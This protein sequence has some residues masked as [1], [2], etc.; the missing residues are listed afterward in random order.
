[1]KIQT[2]VEG[3]GDVIAVPVLLRRLRDEAGAYGL[4]VG[5]PIRSRHSDLVQETS[6]RKVVQLARRQPQCGAILVLLDSDDACPKEKAPEIEAW[7]RAE[8]GDVPVAVVMAKSEFEAWFL[9]A[10]ESL[11]GMRG[12]VENAEPP[13]KPEEIR[14]AKERLEELMLRGRSY[15][16][17]ADQAALAAQFDMSQAYR[18]CRSF[19][20]LA[21]VFGRLVESLG[22]EHNAWPP[23]SWQAGNP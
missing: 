5:R 18:E 15:S 22:V 12:I 23:D 16:E 21:S 6:L 10:V 2:I 7:A 3:Y 8:T 11:R 20:R 9:A 4:D 13:E 19:R 14:G 17:T 1:M